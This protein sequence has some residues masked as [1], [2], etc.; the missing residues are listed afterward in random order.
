M[1]ARLNGT[2]LVVT[3]NVKREDIE[4]LAIRCPDALNLYRGEDDKK[5]LVF[6]VGLTE[7][8]AEIQD[9][10]IVFNSQTHDEVKLATATIMLRGDLGEDPKETI[11]D[12]FGPALKNLK[13]WEAGIPAVLQKVDTEHAELVS[14]V[15][16]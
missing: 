4:K 5:E 15:Q 1:N 14:L 7:G 8:D 2:A 10:C 9:F 13:D 3:S 11:A 12:L 6:T 16:V